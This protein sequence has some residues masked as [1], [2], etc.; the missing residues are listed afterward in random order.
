MRSR[1]MLAAVAALVIGCSSAAGT[2]LT[3]GA[4]ATPQGGGGS[5]Q[6][7]PGGG[8]TG[9]PAVDPSGLGNLLGPGDF[10]AVGVPGAGT[11]TVN[12][13][14]GGA[15]AAYVVFASHPLADGTKDIEIE[16][17]VFTFNS[18]DEASTDFGSQTNDPADPAD[19]Q[20]LGAVRG[21]MFLD[22]PGNDPSTALAEL[23]VLKGRVW[24]SL[25]IPAGPNAQAQLVA[26]TKLALDRAAAL[27]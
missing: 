12:P 24:T 1:L 10:A 6:P 3:D 11:P 16:F 4:T 13:N 9:A 21:Q 17:D 7:L 22:Q 5:L 18:A 23:R 15:G 27:I 14:P 8:P 20:A 2:E 25:V 26:L 19:L